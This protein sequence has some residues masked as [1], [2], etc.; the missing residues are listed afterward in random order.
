MYR[1]KGMLR[2]VEVDVDLVPPDRGG[3]KV[4]GIVFNDANALPLLMVPYE[5][6]DEKTH[7]KTTGF[8]YKVMDVDQEGIV[9]EC[10]LKPA[11]D[12][13]KRMLECLLQIE[14]KK[15]NKQ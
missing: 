11:A 2:G 10:K 15:A 3:Y 7:R 13:S 6:V 4:L 9:Y 12:S 14:Q 8:T 5:I 1:V